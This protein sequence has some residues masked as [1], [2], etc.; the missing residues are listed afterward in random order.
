MEKDLNLDEVLEF[1]KAKHA[2]Q[3]RKGSGEPYIVHPVLVAEIIKDVKPQSHKIE[4]MQAIA[5]LHDTIEDTDTSFVELKKLF[6]V[7]VAST[8]LEL[9]SSK[10]AC[11]YFGKANY[12]SHHIANM[13]PYARTVKLADRLANIRDMKNYTLE[14]KLKTFN[15]T[16]QILEYL[17]KE[18]PEIITGTQARLIELIK[19][20][21]E[22]VILN[23]QTE[24][25]KNK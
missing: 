23:N 17:K 18:C 11:D 2:G 20:D 19:R 5:L 8:V 13:T 16:N 21:I 14:Q 9:T 1:A 12:L 6:G 10:F 7:E 15:E 3:F 22:T 24:R 4:M 25:E